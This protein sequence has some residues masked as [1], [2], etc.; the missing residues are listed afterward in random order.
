MELGVDGEDYGLRAEFAREFSDEFR[1]FDGGSVDGDFVSAG[2][3]NEARVFERADA[4]ASGER[5]GEFGGDT[6]NGFEKSWT[7]IAGGGDVEH[8]EFVGAFGIVAGSE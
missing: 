8:H 5:N 1:P 2:A 6:A 3:D 7:A 4:A